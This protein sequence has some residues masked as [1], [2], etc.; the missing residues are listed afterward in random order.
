METGLDIE[1]HEFQRL[2]HF[3]IS[4]NHLAIKSSIT[5]ASDEHKILLQIIS[6]DLNCS[7]RTYATYETLQELGGRCGIG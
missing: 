2:Y 3:S 6:P 4:C 7:K 5:E 1:N